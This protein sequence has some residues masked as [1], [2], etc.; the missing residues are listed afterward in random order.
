MT[1]ILGRSGIK[2]S[3]IGF[4]CWAIG[5]QAT[6]G[7][8]PMGWGATDDGVSVAAIRRAVDLG[9]TFF[10][11]A[12]IYGAGHSE[13][14]LGRA[15]AGHRHEVVIGTKFGYTFDPQTR[16]ALGEDSSAD[17]IGRA[18]R[19]SLRR[20]NT[21]HIDL[22]QLHRADLPVEDAQGVIAALEDLVADGLI[23]AY[24]W[25]ADDPRRAAAF[26]AG[27]HCT[28][29]QHGANVLTDAPEMFAACDTHDLASVI[30]SPLA[31]GL[32]SGKYTAGSR[33]PADDVR[34]A[35]LGAPA[36]TAGRPTVTW[37]ARAES[38]RAVLTAGGRT[39]AQGALG[40]LLARN[41]RAIPIPGIRTPGQA[42]ENAG[43]IAT[44]PLSPAEMAEISRLLTS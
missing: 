39:P 38:I 36:F 29:I 6:A 21:D 15:L 4:G 31:M 14:V 26:A 37:L 42:E 11:T 10:D 3:D 32:L 40:W 28:A 9:I 35:G 1:R 34:S 2:V 8:Q 27:P 23:R 25:S 44:G 13:M 33:L 18:C 19:A 5:G 41:P 43:A 7:D 22:Y 12:D 16:T 20:L 30:R 17:Y 24:G